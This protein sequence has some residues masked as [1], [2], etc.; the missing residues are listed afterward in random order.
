M[1]ANIRSIEALKQAKAAL[2]KFAE[3]AGALL[4]TVDS[5]VA[6]M[7]QWL[8]HERP[9]HWKSQVRKREEM[10]QAARQEISRKQLAAAPEPASTVLERRA[11]QRAQEKLG[12]A[13]KRQQNTRRWIGVWDKESLMARGSI[14]QLNDFVRVDIPKAIARI[15]RMMEQVEEYL[16]IQA[17]SSD[18][19]AD[20][21]T[22]GEGSASGG[23]ASMARPVSDEKPAISYEYL[24]PFAAEAMP[25]AKPPRES[26]AWSALAIPPLTEQEQFEIYGLA[27]SE[28]KSEQANKRASERGEQGA[29]V[30]T[31]SS[32]SPIPVSPLPIPV[33]LCV[34]STAL[35]K[36]LVWLL[37][38]TPVDEADSGWYLGSLDNPGATGPVWK[39]P[40]AEVLAGR[41]D[42]QTLLSKGFGTLAVLGPEGVIGVY[43]ANGRNVW[44]AEG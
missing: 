30:P 28:E 40:L 23:D 17:P 7:G 1:P 3:D 9:A 15:D 13:Q 24:R 25:R 26:I 41:P 43:D 33:S 37:R 10:V 36:P 19:P 39:V 20:V 21:G 38:S 44:L 32:S 35:D 6:R 16:A 12:E 18:L 2:A 4:A 42:L 27:I 22:V 34:A 31:P 11:L 29:C 8:T 14:S 5:D